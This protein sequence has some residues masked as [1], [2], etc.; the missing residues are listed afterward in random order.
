[1]CAGGDQLHIRAKYYL[2]SPSIRQPLINFETTSSA[3]SFVLKI[4]NACP[5]GTVFS[6][7]KCRKTR[8][9]IAAEKEGIPRQL[10]VAWIGKGG[11]LY[12]LCLDIL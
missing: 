5:M 4:A 3:A 9:I 10:T 12:H 7:I 6:K 11:R 8:G 2:P 1:M